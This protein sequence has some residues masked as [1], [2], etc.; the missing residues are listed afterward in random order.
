MNDAK[1]YTDNTDFR[2]ATLGNVDSGKSTLTGCLTRNI[3]DDGKGRART[4]VLRHMHEKKRGQSSS[5]NTALLGYMSNGQQVIPGGNK[6]VEGI[7]SGAVKPT[8]STTKEI[9]EVASKSNYRVSIIDLCGHQKY[10]KSSIYGLTALN[11]DIALIV[12]GAERGIQRMTKE[13]V[14][15]SCALGISFFLVLTKV[16]LAPPDILKDSQ[17]K[18]KKLLRCAGRK[19]Y[20]VRSIDDIPQAVKCV[21][22]K[23]SSR[24]FVPVFEVSCVNN[25]GLDILREFIRQIAVESLQKQESVNALDL[26]LETADTKERVSK[27]AETHTE[28]IADV[29]I[30]G[31]N[32]ESENTKIASIILDE[33]YC[34]PGVGFVVGGFVERGECHVGS[35]L[36]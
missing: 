20:S 2:I 24:V 17:M 27:T 12:V 13:H 11:P 22:K 14:G 4:F 32:A 1:P 9:C 28:I 8:K 15:L 18:L 5:V 30:A 23:N 34:P 21:E 26:K 25:D 33:V 3:L 10:L 35:K 29:G 31:E 16:D 7:N 19:P 6:L 36:Y